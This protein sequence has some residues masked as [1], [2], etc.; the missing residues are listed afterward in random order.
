MAAAGA[1]EHDKERYTMRKLGEAYAY[2]H[3][4]LMVTS[5]FSAICRRRG[6]NHCLRVGVPPPLVGLVN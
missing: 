5:I 2:V 3:M 6:R 4:G 1:G